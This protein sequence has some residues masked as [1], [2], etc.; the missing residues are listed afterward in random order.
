MLSTTIRCGA[1][2]FATTCQPR[3]GSMSPDMSRLSTSQCRHLCVPSATSLPKPEILF[4][5]IWL[6]FT[7]VVYVNIIVYELDKHEISLYVVL[8]FAFLQEIGLSYHM[9][10]WMII[11]IRMYLMTMFNGSAVFATTCLQR[12]R[13]ML[14]D[15]LRQNTSLRLP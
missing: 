12:K 15:T 11:S 9:N 8:F 6:K 1:V 5:N 10:S 14:R 13:L 7:L 3:V 4:E 2:L